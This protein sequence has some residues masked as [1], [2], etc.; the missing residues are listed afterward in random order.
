MHKF[1]FP[2]MS[3]EQIEKRLRMGQAGSLRRAETVSALGQWKQDAEEMV[4]RGADPDKISAWIS[5]GEEGQMKGGFGHILSSMLDMK[6]ADGK[7]MFSHQDIKQI[8]SAGQGL[9]NNQLIEAKYK[10]AKRILRTKAE[11]QSNN[12]GSPNHP[13]MIELGP[14]ARKFLQLPNR[15]T[16]MKAETNAGS[17]EP[18][19]HSVVGATDYLTPQPGTHPVASND[20]TYELVPNIFSEE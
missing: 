20:G 1:M 2:E 11:K 6:T 12:A 13:V 14:A 5:G 10:E 4:R 19:N 9:H 7:P 16:R 17:G 8:R 15:K 18:V 3:V